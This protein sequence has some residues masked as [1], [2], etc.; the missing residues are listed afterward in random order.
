[1][2]VRVAVVTG[3]SRG[4]G[5]ATALALGNAGFPV[6]VV[7]RS[8][9]ALEETRLLVEQ[10][11]TTAV[12]VVADVTDPEAVARTVAAIERNAGAISVLV[13]NA[14][15]LRAIGPLWETDPGDWWSDVMTSL[16]GAYNFCREIVPRMIARGEG[17]IVNLTSY[18]GARPAPYQS[19]YGCGKAAV[20]SL[21]ESLAAELAEHRLSAF[22]VAPGFTRTEM[23]AHLTSSEAGRRWLPEVGTGDVVDA[24]Q[25]AQLI[26]LIAGGGAD[27][28]SGRLLHTLDEIDVLL[29]G[30]EEIRRDDLYTPRV[31]RLPGR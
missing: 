4:I 2:S 25:T 13:N 18:A 22:S 30:V 27:E 19:A 1:M 7:A 10:T 6:A 24:E 21:T 17:R 15:S 12:A 23:T 26:A 5:R 31:R 9:E 28:L 20:N 29:A 8:A 16:A 14:G 3:A 11:G